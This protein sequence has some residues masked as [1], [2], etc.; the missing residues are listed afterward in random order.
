MLRRALA[1]VHEIFNNQTIR[2]VLSKLRYS[3]FLVVFVV[4]I[5]HIRPSWFWPGFIVTILGELIQVWCFASLEKNRVLASKGLYMLTRNPMYLGRFF[6][7]LG[8]L[9][10]T[11]NISVILVFVVLYYFYMVNR[12]KREE[13]KLR[14]VFGEEY[15]GYCRDVNRFVPSFRGVEW[16]TL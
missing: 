1:R 15:E 13:N 16:R 4:F 3:I 9:L 14:V 7:L 2:S 6:V 12:V 10:L 5:P 11:G 8:F